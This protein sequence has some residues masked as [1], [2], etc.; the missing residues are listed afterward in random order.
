MTP[1]E[2]TQAELSALRSDNERLR[3]HLAGLQKQ[4]KDGE[5]VPVNVAKIQ[6][7]ESR[8]K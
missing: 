4:I 7:K 1:D 2:Q 3:T 6:I 5:L 8:A